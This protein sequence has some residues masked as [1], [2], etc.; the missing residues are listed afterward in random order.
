MCCRKPARSMSGSSSRSTAS[1]DLRRNRNSSMP[2]DL[3]SVERLAEA[4]SA[5]DDAEGSVPASVRIMRLWRA[6]K[7][8]P[9]II[10][11]IDRGASLQRD[12]RLRRA[13]AVDVAAT[14]ARRSREQGDDVVVWLTVIARLAVA[15]SRR[16]FNRLYS[17]AAGVEADRPSD[18]Q[19]Q[20]SRGLA[21]ISEHLNFALRPR[22]PVLKQTEAAECGLACLAMISCYY[23][24][25]TDIT[26]IRSRFAAS[27][28][29][30]RV[31]DLM[32]VAGRVQLATRAVR[33]EL[34]DIGKLRTPAILHWNLDHF[35]VLKRVERK[36]IRIHDPARGDCL[37]PWPQVDRAFSGVALEVWPSAEFA[38]GDER[39][40]IRIRDVTGPIKGLYGYFL[41][42][43]AIGALLEILS[44]CLPVLSQWA[45]DNVVVQADADLLSLLAI[46][47]LS[48]LLL[49][50]VFSA[51]RRWFITYTSST[52]GLQWRT[53]V[54]GHL[55]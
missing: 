4:A 22:L 20:G 52:F 16:T 21:G 54:L 24:H 2:D 49:Q 42:L 40:R 5:H 32:K 41:S 1:R 8:A 15:W 14:L 12:L 27:N 13:Q 38:K 55:V 28:R 6:I 35:V 45:I 33:L 3:D 25:F 37:V 23:G 36:G 10:K 43:F 11:I 44:V 34:N 9:L 7:R 30:M 50:L 48:V 51:F 46:A 31:A 39:R 18:S 47:M 53:S 29:G 17:L 26:Q 19:D